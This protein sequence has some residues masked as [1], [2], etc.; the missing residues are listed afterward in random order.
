MRTG[1]GRHIVL[2]PSYRHGTF[3][4]DGF[5]FFSRARPPIFLADLAIWRLLGGHLVDRLLLGRAKGN[6]IQGNWVAMPIVLKRSK[7]GSRFQWAWGQKRIGSDFCC[8]QRYD[9]NRGH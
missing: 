4:V 5:F 8:R 7:G 3:S 9:R 6:G 1:P 2:D